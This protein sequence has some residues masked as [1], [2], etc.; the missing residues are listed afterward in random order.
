MLRGVPYVVSL[1]GGDVPGTEPDLEQVHL[2]LTPIRRWVLRGATA[3][4]ANSE[5]L[6]SLSEKA[7][8]FPVSVIPN[9]VD[10][11]VFL[12]GSSR[13]GQEFRFV[14]VGR[15]NTQKNVALLLAAAEQLQKDVAI[16]FRVTIVGDGPLV[17]GLRSEAAARGLLAVVD[18]Q[19]WIAR[20]S[21]PSCLAS[22][23]CLVNPSLYEGMP[24]CVLE[25]MACGLPVI[26]S[27]VAG[28]A[29]LV[30]H[31]QTGLLFRSGDKLGL[32][33]AMRRVLEGRDAALAWGRTGRATVEKHYSWSAAANAYV[34]L[35]RPA[36][37]EAS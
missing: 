19:P 32:A 1:R 23:D 16:P 30:A 26:A 35:F 14:F 21:M 17:N 15:L 28:N 10:T 33:S 5:G 34:R 37:I 25:A 13:Q 27:D 9:G 18:W 20:T 7:D 2:A 8:P 29:D 22:V 36:A 6:R 4:V 31:E 24:N 3:V 12:P 11:A